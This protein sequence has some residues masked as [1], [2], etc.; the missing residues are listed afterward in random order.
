MLLTH[1]DAAEA[2]ARFMVRTGLLGQF[3]EADD[4]A[5][6]ME[7]PKESEGTGSDLNGVSKGSEDTGKVGRVNGSGGFM[8]RIK[9]GVTV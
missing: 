3:R 2:M 7:E 9:D 5:I 1:H 4:A 8:M 6:G